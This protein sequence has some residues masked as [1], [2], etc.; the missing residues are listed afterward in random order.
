MTSH[1]IFGISIHGSLN[2]WVG[3]E[4]FYNLKYICAGLSNTLEYT[5]GWSDFKW[6][7]ANGRVPSEITPRARR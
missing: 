7:N 5:G 2:G 6:A 1:D 3:D 4:K